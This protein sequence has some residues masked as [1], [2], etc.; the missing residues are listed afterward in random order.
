MRSK[1]SFAYQLAIVRI[2]FLHSN[3][4]YK[5][6]KERF[7][8]SN[9]TFTREGKWPRMSRHGT[10]LWFLF[11]FP[12]L[13]TQFHKSFQLQHCFSYIRKKLWA[14]FLS[15]T[16]KWHCKI[17]IGKWLHFLGIALGYIVVCRYVKSKLMQQNFNVTGDCA[18]QRPGGTDSD[19]SL[20]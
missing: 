10:F 12:M 14:I 3:L 17:A 8:D 4:L 6:W 1:L 5:S 15:L 9:G 16:N 19:W 13:R 11:F 20:E 18:R 7:R 2:I